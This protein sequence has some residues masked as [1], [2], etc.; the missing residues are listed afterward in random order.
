MSTSDSQV[1]KDITTSTPGVI[2]QFLVDPDGNWSFIYVSKGIEDLFEVTPED[3][4]READIMT[5]CIIEEDRP[6]HRQSVEYAV[7]N[8]TPWHHEHRI[9][10][11]SG[12]TK[13][14]LATA[15]PRP[16]E[17]GGVLWN[18]ILTD[19]TAA[20]EM[21]LA[22]A[23]F[24]NINLQQMQNIALMEAKLREHQMIISRN[25]SVIL[26]YSGPVGSKY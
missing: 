6:S 3:A 26:H 10:T 1:L 20:K 14:I 15:L 4:C 13:W 2:Y 9:L 17:D 21:K 25:R 5:N 18:G 23:D 22:I 7:K 16:L 12:V 19:V 24:N 11:R 8:V